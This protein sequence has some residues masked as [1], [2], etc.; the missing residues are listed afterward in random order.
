MKLNQ[1]INFNRILEK[2]ICKRMKV[3]INEEDI[4][5][6]SQ[7]GFREDHS[8]QHAIIDIVNTIQSNMD[9]R[10]YS[11]GVF[12]DL[13]KAF[14]TVDHAILLDK[15]NHYGFRGIINKWFS[16]YLQDRTQTS[17]VGPHISERTLTTCGVP[18]G[19]VL[20]PLLFLL[21]IN[22]IY[23]CSKKLNFYLFADDTNI[24]YADKNLKSLEYTVN[25]ELH[26]LYVWLTSNKLSLNIKKSNFV[27]FRP[28]QKRLPFQPK[29]SIFDNE[30]NMNVFLDCK[31][32]VKYL[33]ILL[34]YN[35]S[36]KNHIEYIALNY[37]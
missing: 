11:C 34:D 37:H 31:D 3:F 18:Q 23:T 13:K 20:G 24:L 15:L 30:K 22:D 32:Y 5:Y 14:D 16:S 19:S 27:I 26:K 36:W 9:K 35:L 25:A 6:P 2:L 21:Y 33:G 1:T 29:I 7:Y 4:L 12:I 10:L 8:T 17:Q 28:Y